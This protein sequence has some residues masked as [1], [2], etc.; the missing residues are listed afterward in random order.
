MAHDKTIDWKVHL[1]LIVLVFQFLVVTFVNNNKYLIIILCF[2]HQMHP[3]GC[4]L[5]LL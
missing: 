4:L 5:L 2:V 3:I 1:E